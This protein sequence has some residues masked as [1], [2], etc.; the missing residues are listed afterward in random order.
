MSAEISPIPYANDLGF[1]LLS[2]SA[3]G[4]EF[5]LASEERFMGNPLLRAFHGGVICG[6]MECA[7]SET[8][9]RILGYDAQPRLINLTTSFLGSAQVDQALRVETEVTKAGRRFVGVYA[10]SYQGSVDRIVAKASALFRVSEGSPAP[11]FGE[12]GHGG[13]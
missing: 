3:R 4:A 8:V 2:I 6:F 12:R 7:M 5:E 11:S 13:G 1:R 9:M 10:R